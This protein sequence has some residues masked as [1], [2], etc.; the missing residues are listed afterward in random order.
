MWAWREGASA[1]G[2]REA[3][4]PGGSALAPIMNLR[5]ECA[6]ARGPAR[7]PGKAAPA[8]PRRPRAGGRAARQRGGGGGGRRGDGLPLVGKAQGQDR[9]RGQ[10]GGLQV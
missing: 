7:V 2:G 4:P 10:V 5:L 3:L 8:P 9:G 6:P 1:L